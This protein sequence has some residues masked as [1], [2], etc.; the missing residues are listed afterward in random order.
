MRNNTREAETG[1]QK[2]GL[3]LDELVRVGARQV[4]Q[5]AIEAELTQLL[6]MRPTPPPVQTTVAVLARNGRS[7]SIRLCGQV[8]SF[9]RV[10]FSQAKGSMS[11]ALA[12]ANKV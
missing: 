9:S 8:G 3:G 4:I 5:Q 6:G 7:S 12:V 2:T 1:L 10:S 11:L